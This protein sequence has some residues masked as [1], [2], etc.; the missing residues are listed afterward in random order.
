MVISRA[1]TTTTEE[2]IRRVFGYLNFGEIERIDIIPYQSREGKDWLKI[3]IHYASSSSNAD[4]LRERL[5]DNDKRQKKDGEM[6]VEPVK[7][8]Y[9]HKHFWQ[10]YKAK[11]D[12]ERRAEKADLHATQTTGFIPRIEM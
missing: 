2:D 5:D 1:F 11:T 6:N 8:F 4:R 12:A 3:F 9:D 7:V 10:V